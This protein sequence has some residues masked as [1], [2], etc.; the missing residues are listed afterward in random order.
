MKNTAFAF[1]LMAGALFSCDDND[2]VKPDDVPAA[3][4]ETLLTS[5][6]NATDVDWE[7]LGEDFEADFDV[8]TVDYS[9]LI[10]SSGSLLKQ[11]QDILETELPEAVRT[12]IEGA[13]A[14]YKIDDSELLLQGQTT[15]YQVELDDNTREEK[16]VYSADGQ[17][18][19]QDYWD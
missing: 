18:V 10:N 2:D 5:F 6:P 9:A 11:K 14:G 1:L 13:Y 3:V 12:A 4:K 15:L 7:K 8:D 19:Q 17:L 16:L